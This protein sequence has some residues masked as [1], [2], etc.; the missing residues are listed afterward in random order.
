MATNTNFQ[1]LNTDMG[2]TIAKSDDF[3]NN[4]VDRYHQIADTLLGNELSV[5]DLQ[6]DAHALQM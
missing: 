1:S 5:E 4:L 2:L 6:I 3:T